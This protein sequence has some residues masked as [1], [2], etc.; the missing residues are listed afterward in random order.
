MAWLTGAFISVMASNM[1]HSAG[2]SDWVVVT[3]LATI[4]CLAGA[5]Y[6]SLR[7]LASAGWLGR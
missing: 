7:G 3:F 2:N 5:A 4:A 6:C 1:L